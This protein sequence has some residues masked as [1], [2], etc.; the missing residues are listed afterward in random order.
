MAI[1]SNRL[2]LLKFWHSQSAG[3][4]HFRCG[5][6]SDHFF[7]FRKGPLPETDDFLVVIQNAK[8]VAVTISF[9]VRALADRK[10]FW[11]LFQL[12]AL[13]G[14]LLIRVKPAGSV[15]EPAPDKDPFTD[16]LVSWLPAAFWSLSENDCLLIFERHI[17]LFLSLRSL[18]LL[19]IY[20]LHIFCLLCRSLFPKKNAIRENESHFWYWF[21]ICVAVLWMTALSDFSSRNENHSDCCLDRN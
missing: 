1:D 11:L 12:L 7:S 2:H 8:R 6:V 20:L 15:K 19:P 14:C 16:W 17:G 5:F 9:F 21:W 4:I 13:S 10:L 18:C 3:N